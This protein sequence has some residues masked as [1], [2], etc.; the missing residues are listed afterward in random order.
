LVVVVVEVEVVKIH[1]HLH[2]PVC[3]YSR[4]NKLQYLRRRFID[5]GSIGT[6]INFPGIIH[7][8][9]S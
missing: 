1:L 7:T 4:F 3:R 6:V 8:V 2:V 5:F 9:L